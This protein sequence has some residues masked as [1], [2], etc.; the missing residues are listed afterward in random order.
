MI[1]MRAPAEASADP[2]AIEHGVQ[3]AFI[4]C[5]GRDVA[6]VVTDAPLTTVVSAPCR[7]WLADGGTAVLSTCLHEARRERDAIHLENF[8]RAQRMAAAS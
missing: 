1:W 5:V 2:E 8:K 7:A 6:P 4:D 3:D